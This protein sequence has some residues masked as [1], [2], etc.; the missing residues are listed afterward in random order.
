M[1]NKRMIK[2]R[3]ECRFKAAAGG[4]RAM[5]SPDVSPRCYPPSSGIPDDFVSDDD[6]VL[7][8]VTTDRGGCQH[9]EM[10]RAVARWGNRVENALEGHAALGIDLQ[11]PMLIKRCPDGKGRLIGR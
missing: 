2:N 7:I 11:D 1:V 3:D 8:G 10:R 5:F 4:S 9:T 6:E